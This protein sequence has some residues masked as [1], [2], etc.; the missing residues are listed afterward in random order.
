[1]FNIIGYYKIKQENTVLYQS[2]NLI[3]LLGESF[4]LNR[5]INNSLNP[6]K[7]IVLGNSETIPLKSDEKLGNEKFR[8]TCN[9]E[10]DLNN[11]RIRLTA[12][13]SSD[14]IVGITE[15]GVANDSFL[16][17]H[18]TFHEIESDLLV[19]PIGSVDI[20]YSF[21][22]STGTLRQNWIKVPNLINTYSIFEPSLVIGVIEKDSGT[23]YRKLGTI[24]KVDEIDCSY[25]YDINTSNLYVQC[26]SDV[27]SDEYLSPNEVD[28]IIQTK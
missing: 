20:E 21:Q 6:M 9:R 25:Y 16:I 23:G 7:Y 19:N 28:L 5:C 26:G 3:T 8:R 15:I 2:G 4:F 18:D 27:T 22:F 1:M 13:F 17:S 14:E 11:K 10:V 24:Q 12:S